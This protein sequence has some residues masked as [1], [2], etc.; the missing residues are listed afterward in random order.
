MHLA[1]QRLSNKEIARELNIAVGT[2]KN[3]LARAA[4]KTEASGRMATA[5]R[6]GIVDTVTEMHIVH[7]VVSDVAERATGDDRAATGSRRWPL[8]PPPRGLLRLGYIV[9]FFVGGCLVI[10]LGVLTIVT[11]MD[12]AAGRAPP[13]AIRAV[14]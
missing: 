1:A 9:A 12:L 3:H 7:P 2:V 13:N 11:T 8:P 5:R 6:L 4:A 10:T 14:Q